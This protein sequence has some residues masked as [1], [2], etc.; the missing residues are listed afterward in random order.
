[1]FRLGNRV[2]KQDRDR[3]LNV[4]GNKPGKC[5][6]PKAKRQ[7]ILKRQVMIISENVI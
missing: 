3:T 2:N 7:D 1:M 4:P 6:F 5:G